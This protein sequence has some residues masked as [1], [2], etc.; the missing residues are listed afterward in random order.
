MAF[1]NVAQIFG[2][3]PARYNEDPSFKVGDVQ[4][5]AQ[6]PG[7]PTNHNPVA[8]D[9]ADPANAHSLFQ[10]VPKWFVL[11]DLMH[12]W[13]GGKKMAR[14][15]DKWKGKQWK[16]IQNNSDSPAPF[17]IVTYIS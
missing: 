15:Q 9:N 7:D 2:A 13:Y 4:E 6:A 16:K 17:P 8:S 10:I 1:Y 5:S 14:Q 11:F 12:E 3:G